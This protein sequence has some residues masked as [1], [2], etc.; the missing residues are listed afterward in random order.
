MISVPAATMGHGSR[1]V[2][3]PDGRILYV[4]CENRLWALNSWTFDIKD[5]LT[6]SF[7][8]DG[9][10][11]LA[12]AAANRK[13]PFGLWTVATP[14]LR[15]ARHTEDWSRVHC[16]FIALGTSSRKFQVRKGYE[17]FYV[18][19]YLCVSVGSHFQEGCARVSLLFGNVVTKGGANGETD[20]G[21]NRKRG[22]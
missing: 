7:A 19:P 9:K 16:P 4:G 11:L 2:V 6:L 14:G 18:K 17:T 8:L 1:A 13:L 20:T 3:S 10:V 12:T 21:R 15:L 5:E 22:T